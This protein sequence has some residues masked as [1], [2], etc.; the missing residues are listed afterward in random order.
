MTVDA[1]LQDSEVSLPHYAA[2]AVDQSLDMDLTY[3]IPPEFFPVL[4]VGLRV[5]VPP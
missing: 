4:H 2:I 5:Q 1:T 3:G